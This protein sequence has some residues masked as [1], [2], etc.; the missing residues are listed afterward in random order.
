MAECLVAVRSHGVLR[1]TQP[2]ILPL[3]PTNY[4]NDELT[5]KERGAEELKVFQNHGEK[6]GN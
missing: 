1:D 5:I 4:L 3:T 2:Q 6:R